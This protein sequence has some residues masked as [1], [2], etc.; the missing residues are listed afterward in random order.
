MAQL[1]FDCQ[2]FCCSHLDALEDVAIEDIL[3]Q[4]GARYHFRDATIGA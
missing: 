4:Y 2:V 1:G 3:D